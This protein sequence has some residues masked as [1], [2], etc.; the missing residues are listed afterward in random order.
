MTRRREEPQDDEPDP[1]VTVS[2]GP[3][4]SPLIVRAEPGSGRMILEGPAG[5]YDVTLSFENTFSRTLGE[6][7]S[8]VSLGSWGSLVLVLAAR[9]L[10]RRRG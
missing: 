6:I 4:P 2:P 8:Q 7:L 10:W 1:N 5:K 3:P 9:S